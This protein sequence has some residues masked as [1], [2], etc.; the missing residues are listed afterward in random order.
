VRAQSSELRK[1]LSVSAKPRMP[2]SYVPPPSQR[3]KS[4]SRTATT[5]D[6]LDDDDD[7]ELA[8]RRLQAERVVFQFLKDRK[9]QQ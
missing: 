4:I 1:S 8:V 7:P 5:D 6:F 2:G 9:H 3:D